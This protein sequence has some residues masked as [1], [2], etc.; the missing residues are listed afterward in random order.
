MDD[1]LSNFGA[2]LLAMEENER[3][4]NDIVQIQV[5]ERL[6]ITTRGTLTSGSDY[7]QKHFADPN[8]TNK[9]L[10]L[11]LDPDVFQYVLRYLRHGTMPLFYDRTK[12]HD[13]AHYRT[14]ADVAQKL[15]VARLSSWCMEARFTDALRI[16]RSVEVHRDVEPEDVALL[17]GG[18]TRA[19]LGKTIL[20]PRWLVKRVWV[21]PSAILGHAED[22]AV[23]REQCPGL[24]V[25]GDRWRERVVLDVLV[26]KKALVLNRCWWGML[27]DKG[28]SNGV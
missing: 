24:S 27:G 13:F 4:R 10:F 11:D 23:C 3:H 26:I 1:Y 7:F 6:F 28:H 17:A 18:E 5:G 8:L 2:D 20:H 9:R 19:G 25:E 15:G 16:Q 12:G 14:L 22:P 21:C